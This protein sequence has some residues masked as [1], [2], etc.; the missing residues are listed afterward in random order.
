MAAALARAAGP[1]RGAHQ[2]R[3]FAAVDVVGMERGGDRR[4]LLAEIERDLAGEIARSELQL[5]GGRVGLGPLH[6]LCDRRAAQLQMQGLTLERTGR[7]QLQAPG[8]TAIGATSVASDLVEI[9]DHAAAAAV[10]DIADRGSRDPQL[11]DLGDRRRAFRETLFEFP[12]RGSVGARLQPEHGLGDADLGQHEPAVQQRPE[13]DHEF[14]PLHRE[15]RAIARPVRIGKTQ[16]VGGDLGVKR[17]IDIEW[18]P[19]LELAPER[20]RDAPLQRALEPVPVEQG[21][22][23]TS[24]ASTPSGNKSH[25]RR[26]LIEG[27]GSDLKCLI[28]P[29]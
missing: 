17:Q 23:T 28:T 15:H 10:V 27:R 7:G 18:P 29:P 16:V 1:G 11:P 26:R 9:G 19:D 6:E 4:H 13:V 22:E 2:S 12:V 8:R 14:G 25:Q 3:Q 24:A 20:G 5:D 21:Q